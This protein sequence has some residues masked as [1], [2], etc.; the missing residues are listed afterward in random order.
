MRRIPIYILKD[1]AKKY[2]YTHIIMLAHGHTEKGG[3]D[4]VATYGVSRQESYEA[5]SFGNLL[6]DKLGWPRSLHARSSRIK[7]T[8]SELARLRRENSALK[9]E[10]EQL[11][12]ESTAKFSIPVVASGIQVVGDG[13]MFPDGWNPSGPKCPE[14]GVF[15][16]YHMFGCPR[17]E[18]GYDKHMP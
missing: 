13:T 10:I 6:K 5:S 4:F 3:M 7:H 11:K 12:K 17:S 16:P 9:K 2:G 14:C 1:I 8:L 15:E 18:L